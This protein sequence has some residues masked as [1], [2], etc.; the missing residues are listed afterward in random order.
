MALD[1][2]LQ[3]KVVIL[4]MKEV[5]LLVVCIKGFKLKYLVVILIMKEVVLLDTGKEITFNEVVS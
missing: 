3:N 1:Y 5:V 4:I 2:N